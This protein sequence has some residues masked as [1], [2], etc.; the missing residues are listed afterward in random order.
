MTRYH[1]IPCG[2]FYNRADAIAFAQECQC[3][4]KRIITVHYYA[5]HGYSV[6]VGSVNDEHET[7]IYTLTPKLVVY[8][9]KAGV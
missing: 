6:Q 2:L 5:G 1:N 9:R 7:C 3:S 8:T 4:C